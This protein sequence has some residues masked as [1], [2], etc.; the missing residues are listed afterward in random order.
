MADW[1]PGALRLVL[2]TPGDRSP[3][4]TLALVAACAGAGLGSLIV[5]EPQLPD[6]ELRRLLAQ[7]V[8]LCRQAGVTVLVSNRPELAAECGADGVQLGH[9]GPAPAAVRAA[10]PELLVS[11]SAHRDQLD[12]G[13][14]DLARADAVTLSH[15]AP[16]HRSHARPLLTGAEVARLLTELAPL[17]VVLLG[18][19]TAKQVPELPDGLAGVAVIRALADASDPARAT[20]ELAAAL[21]TRWPG[22]ASA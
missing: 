8:P 22:Q 10:H 14:L 9:G 2:V 1:L 19:L 20:R 16:T 7:L 11:L 5:R 4:A 6:D 17:P 21:Q 18:G 12:A 13:V 3:A 15:W